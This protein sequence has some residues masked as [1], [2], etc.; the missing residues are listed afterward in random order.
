MLEIASLCKT[1]GF[2]NESI[3][4]FSMTLSKPHSFAQEL[5][6]F[7]NLGQLYYFKGEL[8]KAVQY[9]GFLKGCDYKQ[10]KVQDIYEHL[11]LFKE[12]LEDVDI[13][14]ENANADERSIFTANGD[15]V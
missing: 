15:N 2:I 11:I 1:E 10:S 3:Y 7:E 8:D 13:F 14:D 9:Y 5:I 12:K 6:V 4:F